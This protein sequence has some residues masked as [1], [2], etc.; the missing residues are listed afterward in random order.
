MNYK[1]YVKER[2]GTFRHQYIYDGK[3]KKKIGV[4]VYKDGNFGWSLCSEKDTFSKYKGKAIA[5]LRAESGKSSILKIPFK[6]FR[7]MPQIEDKVVKLK[8]NMRVV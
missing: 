1:K 4:V 6:Y 5:L 8:D 3:N 7:I 2:E